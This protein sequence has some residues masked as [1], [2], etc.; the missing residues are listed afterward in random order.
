MIHIYNIAAWNAN[1]LLQRIKEVEVFINT[2]NIDIL[3][4]SETHFTEQ[5]YVN[6][7]NYITYA[8][9]HPDEKAPTG[10]AIIIRKDIKHH[11]LPKYET[12]HIQATN[13]IED[14]DGNLTISAIYRP[15]RHTIKKEQY[16]AFIN[17][18][19]H[20]FLAGGYFN[21]NHQHWGS[22]LINHKG[23]EQYQSIQEKQLEILSTGEP[24]YCQQIST[25]FQTY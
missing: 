3:L 18:L 21:A 20:R 23:R 7:P 14:W 11:E 19:R 13:S 17:S 24:T 1:A 6:I 4:V 25:K 16:N 8:T 9:N 5:N 2:Q 10:S 12:D 15:P 22:H